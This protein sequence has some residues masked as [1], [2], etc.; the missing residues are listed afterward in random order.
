MTII[1]A[2]VSGVVQGITEFFPISS[3]GHL[4]LLHNIMGFKEEM[5]AFDLFLHFGT[6]ISVVA[7]FW[8][9]IFQMFQKDTRLLKFIII[10]S[11]PTFIIGMVFKDIVERLFSMPSA[12]GYSLIVTGIFLLVASTCGIYWKIVRRSRP[13]GVVN[14]IIIGIAQGI[15]IVPGVSRSGATIGTALIAGLNESEALKFS[16]LLSIPAVLGANILKVR[17]I[18]GNLISG[19]TA[20]F[21]VGS[22]AAAVTGFLVIKVLFS[23]LRKNIFFLF[24]IYCILIG[25]AVIILYR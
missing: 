1:Q 21:L 9:D 18:Y 10:A 22:I 2:V 4:V 14:S 11:I 25:A 23:I 20:V 16:F 12:V 8:K 17:H 5:L 3:S 24:G 6:I 7:F 15:A 19:D 13:L